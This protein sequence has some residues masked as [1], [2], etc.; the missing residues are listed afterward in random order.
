MVSFSVLRGIDDSFCEVGKVFASRSSEV[1]WSHQSMASKH[2]MN[3]FNAE[4]EG[5]RHDNSRRTRGNR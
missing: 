2:L 4:Q 3:A 5:Q 1:D